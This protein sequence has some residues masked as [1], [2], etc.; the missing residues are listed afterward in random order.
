ME[1]QHEVDERP[2]ELRA[3]TDQHREPGAGDLGASLEVDDPER[4]PEIP[5]SL[6]SETE[7]AW[8]AVPAHFDVVRGAAP[9]GYARVRH[10]WKDLQPPEPLLFERGQ[11]C[12]LGLD[13]LGALPILLL[14]RR[15]VLALAFGTCDLLRRAVLVALQSL[16]LGQQPASLGLDGDQR[17]QLGREV[18]ATVPKG[19]SDTVQVIAKKGRIQHGP[20]LPGMRACRRGR[21]RHRAAPRSAGRDPGVS[22][23]TALGS[24]RA[25]A[26]PPSRTWSLR[27]APPSTSSSTTRTRWR[28][29]PCLNS[30]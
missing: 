17:I 10:V 2:R 19:R 25:R 3:G 12:V 11:R 24:T 14:Q 27:R 16:E 22:P 13:R 8:R 21:Q 20:I 9:D 4:G 1:L 5:V 26:Q 30:R 29:C 18:G 7:G 28:P 6:R 23:W 15:G